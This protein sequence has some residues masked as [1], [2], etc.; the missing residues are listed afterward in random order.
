MDEI[1]TKLE[2]ELADVRAQI[3]SGKHRAKRAAV[4]DEL[5]LEAA[6]ADLRSLRTRLGVLEANRQKL[7]SGVNC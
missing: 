4:G 5:A 1:K 7:A 6:E 2:A 3:E